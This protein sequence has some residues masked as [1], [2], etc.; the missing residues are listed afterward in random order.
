MILTHEGKTDAEIQTI[1]GV[2]PNAIRTLRSRIKAKLN[3]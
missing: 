3:S 2:G 1:F